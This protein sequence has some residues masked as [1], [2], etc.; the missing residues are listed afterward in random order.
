[1]KF[2]YDADNNGQY[3]DGAIFANTANQQVDWSIYMTDAH[4]AIV[5][6]GAQ[7]PAAVISPNGGEILV[8]GKQAEITWDSS[9]IAGDKVDLYVLHDD[10]SSLLSSAGGSL[11]DRINA[12]NWYQFA[13]AVN[14]S[15]SYAF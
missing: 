12:R 3:D 1:M 15:G 2:E 10:P 7:R 14:N 13:S 4:Q 9:Q 8:T 11:A 6:D 5:I